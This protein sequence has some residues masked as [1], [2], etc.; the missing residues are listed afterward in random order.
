MNKNKTK[1]NALK[2]NRSTEQMER[3]ERLERMERFVN[4]IA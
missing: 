1:A 2:G 4:S 3:M